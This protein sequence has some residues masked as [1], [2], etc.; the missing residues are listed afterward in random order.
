[1]DYTCGINTHQVPEDG[2][3]GRKIGC[4]FQNVFERQFVVPFEL[5][6]SGKGASSRRI[7]PNQYFSF[8]EA[9]FTMAIVLVSGR[10]CRIFSMRAGRSCAI[11]TT[12]SYSVNL[13]R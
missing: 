13:S 6:P 1:M 5:D 12:V 7:S 9:P 8:G 4:V 2:A 10:T 11:A 3:V